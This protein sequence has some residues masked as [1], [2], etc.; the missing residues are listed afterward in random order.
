MTT[1]G[2]IQGK[3]GQYPVYHP[4]RLFNTKLAIWLIVFPFMLSISRAQ[5]ARPVAT[6][7]ESN[8][9]RP[10]PGSLILCGK[11]E[12]PDYVFKSF[13]QLCQVNDPES[14]NFVIVFSDNQVNRAHTVLKSLCGDKVELVDVSSDDAI[15]KMPD[16]IRERIKKC[17]GVWLDLTSP[18]SEE[19]FASLMVREVF[20]QGK[21]VGAAGNWASQMLSISPSENDKWGGLQLIPHCRM[22]LVATN[23]GKHP[24]ATTLE[25]GLMHWLVP[26]QSAL[27]FL[28]GRLAS[29]HGNG[30]VRKAG[31]SLSG[32]AVDETLNLVDLETGEPI[33]GSDFLEQLRSFTFDPE[34]RQPLRS[35]FSG[36]EKGTLILSG[37]G[38]VSDSTFQS[39]IE[40]AGGKEARFVC[41][42]TAGD[43]DDKSYSARRLKELGCN[44]IEILHTRDPRVA[45]RDTRILKLLDEANAVWIDGGRTYRVMEAYQETQVQKKIHALLQRGGVFGGSSAGCQVASELLVRGNPSNADQLEYPPFSRGLGLLTG[46]VFDAHFRKRHREYEFGYLIVLHPDLLGIG[47]D[48][49]TSIVV[50]GEIATVEGENGVTLFDARQP[51][52]T[53]PTT[54][55]PRQTFLK[56]GSRFNLK[57]RKQIQ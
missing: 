48:E 22:H 32:D 40:A 45:D 39:F 2:Y 7:P 53:G 15:R 29:S 21:V 13:A 27:V 12:F 24:A 47:I 55:A 1:I 20:E 18:P 35:D 16:A 37:G 31:V 41:I 49:E 51:V 26:S 28:R 11:G 46:V 14:K 17:S 8:L 42:P 38:G 52:A 43:D 4:S 44:N 10:I 25:K 3:Q 23:D 36:P 54:N 6:R 56:S 57:T 30:H 5:L 33:G 34:K 19:K 9:I 50:K